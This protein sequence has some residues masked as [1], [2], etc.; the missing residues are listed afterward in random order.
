[1]AELPELRRCAAGAARC[2]AGAARC[3]AGAARCVHRPLL[4]HAFAIRRRA[5]AGDAS[6]CM[7]PCSARPWALLSSVLGCLLSSAVAGLAWRGCYCCCCDHSEAATPPLLCRPVPCCR[8][9]A[10][11]AGVVAPASGWVAAS[12]S[13]VAAV[14]PCPRRRPAASAARRQGRPRRWDPRPGAWRRPGRPCAHTPSKRAW[15]PRRR[16]GRLGGRYGTYVPSQRSGSRSSS[17]TSQA[18]ISRAEWS[19]S[20]STERS[21]SSCLRPNG[22][23]EA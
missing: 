14:A 6:T 1:M 11:A 22:S 16:R 17:S 9:E 10:L 18:A 12:G 21:K 5:A 23:G 3:A 19:E 7:P 4:P 8:F 20:N 15:V 13:A 2:A